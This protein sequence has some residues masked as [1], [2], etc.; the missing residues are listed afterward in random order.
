MTNTEKVL[1]ITVGFSTTNKLISRV[2]RW[3]TRGKVSHAWIAFFDP[4]LD[5]RLVMQAEAW[6]FEVRTWARWKSRNQLVVEFRPAL[7]VAKSLRWIAKSLGVKYDWRSAF[8]VGLRRW[9]GT[10]LR[11]KFN[12]PGKLMCSEAV[13]RFLQHA[14]VAEVARF[15]PEVTSPQRLLEVMEKSPHF[16]PVQR[17][18]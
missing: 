10:W 16:S 8:F 14:G 5:T 18:R 1:D 13:I 15:D 9:F 17:E 3:V 7:P 6:G 2:I 4:C 11:G 12:S